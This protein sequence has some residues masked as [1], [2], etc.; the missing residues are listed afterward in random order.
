MSEL[1]RIQINEIFYEWR[2]IEEI[3]NDVT[4]ERY[5]AIGLRT[6]RLDEDNEVH[7]HFSEAMRKKISKAWSR[8]F[9]CT[10]SIREEEGLRISTCHEVHCRICLKHL[11]KYRKLC[12]ECFPFAPED[13]Y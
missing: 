2:K 7:Q 8:C 12:K 1:D 9:R 13:D 5:F 11:G 6:V 10:R 4:K 3:M